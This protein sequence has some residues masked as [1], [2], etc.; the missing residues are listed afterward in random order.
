MID[1]H[2]Y[3]KTR[4]PEAESA[5]TFGIISLVC[6]AL[7]FI[8]GCPTGIIGIIL[9]FI[10]ASKAKKVK[11]DF[12]ASPGIYHV[13][14]LQKADTARTM[15]LIS[16]IIGIVITILWI[17]FMGFIVLVNYLENNF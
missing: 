7:T 13:D 3:T 10:A 6:L 11:V 9:G 16:A 15:G 8:C 4:H 17:V 2:F 5:H 1:T 12:L 14:S